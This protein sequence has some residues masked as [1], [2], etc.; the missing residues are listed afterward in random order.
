MNAYDG[1]VKRGRRVGER[2]AQRRRQ[3]AARHA[4]AKATEHSVRQR[5]AEL[6]ASVRASLPPSD[7]PFAPEFQVKLDAA[8]E[9]FEQRVNAQ[10]GA[11][12]ERLGSAAGIVQGFIADAESVADR[13]AIESDAAVQDVFQQLRAGEL[14]R[15]QLAIL[16]RILSARLGETELAIQEAREACDSAARTVEHWTRRVA[17]AVEHEAADLAEQATVRV[18]ES[19]VAVRATDAALR[20]YEEL[21]ET[22]RDLGRRV[23]DAAEHE[24]DRSS[25]VR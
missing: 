8:I 14:S 3:Q 4:E 19:K 17:T 1:R 18:E 16:A 23:L 21:R 2:R 6:D 22:L 12:T 13:A 7:P 25:S 11:T 5:C 20:E 9:R 10:L 15:K 24:S